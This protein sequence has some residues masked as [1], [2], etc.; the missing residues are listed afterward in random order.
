MKEVRRAVDFELLTRLTSTFGP[1]G[2]EA[3]IRDLIHR[4]VEPF[5][6]EDLP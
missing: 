1:S 5:G 6:G 3:A 2:H 4:E